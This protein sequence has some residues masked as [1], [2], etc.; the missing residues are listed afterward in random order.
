MNA[1]FKDLVHWAL[2]ANIRLK[3]FLFFSFLSIPKL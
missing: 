3:M 2:E 1:P